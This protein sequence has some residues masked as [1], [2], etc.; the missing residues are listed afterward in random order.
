MSTKSPF[1]EFALVT[2]SLVLLYTA[3][4]K[5]YFPTD[6]IAVHFCSCSS[7]NLMLH[8]CFSQ[9]V[10]SR[11]GD[12]SGTRLHILHYRL[13]ITL[14][15]K[16]VIEKG[17]SRALPPPSRFPLEAHIVRDA[18][19]PR[20][21]T[22]ANQECPGARAQAMLVN[23]QSSRVHTHKRSPAQWTTTAA[24]CQRNERTLQ[25]STSLSLLPPPPVSVL[26]SQVGSPAST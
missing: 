10:L 20:T 3:R 11:R 18:S 13:S 1:A 21:V 16:Q 2:S 23:Y 17:L 14:L 15:K 22:T 9:S 12:A 24:K 19:E 4:F 5:H 26:G 25:T 6:H 8:S 7:F